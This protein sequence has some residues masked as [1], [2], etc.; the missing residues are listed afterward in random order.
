MSVV[1]PVAAAMTV[2][3]KA[4]CSLLGT[5]L[6]ITT[7]RTNQN[8]RVVIVANTTQAIAIDSNVSLPSNSR[9]VSST[10]NRSSAGN[11]GK[12]M[13]VWPSCTMPSMPRLPVGTLRWPSSS[14][15]AWM[16]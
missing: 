8:S 1:P 2:A 10:G 12:Y 15:R 3:A 16:S 13:C 7:L 11:R 4:A 14:A 6:P 5:R 9:V